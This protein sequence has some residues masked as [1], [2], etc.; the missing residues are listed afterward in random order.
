MILFFEIEFYSIGYTFYFYGNAIDNLRLIFKLFS[1]PNRISFKSWVTRF[2]NLYISNIADC[3]HCKHYSYIPFC[4][5]FKQPCWILWRYTED[6]LLNSFNNRKICMVSF[7]GTIGILATL[8]GTCGL[9][10]LPLG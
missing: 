4:S 1:C 3:C 9:A 5:V 8:I 10:P 6:R 2:Y 7:F